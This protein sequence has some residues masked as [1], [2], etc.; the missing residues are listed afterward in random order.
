MRIIGGRF[1]GHALKAPHGAGVRPTSDRLRETLFNVLAHAYADPVPQ[2]RVLDLFAGTGALGLEAMSRGASFC[3]FVDDG[4]E[5]RG[6]IRDNI[7]KLGFGGATRVFRRDAT[8]LGTAPAGSFD[9]VFCDPP[10]GR[11]LA[12]RALGAAH[13]GGWIAPGALAAVEEDGTAEIA[14]PQGFERIETRN[15]GDSQLLFFR[16]A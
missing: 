15:Y 2:A 11:G 6:L 16:A 4:V 5:S 8:R 7:E 1:R 10:Y 13:A 14:T 9:L 3:L 12:E